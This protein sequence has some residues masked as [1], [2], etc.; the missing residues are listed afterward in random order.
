MTE[1]A[2]Q[3]KPEL[4]E[5]DQSIKEA[6]EE[7]PEESAPQTEE[8]SEPK[9]VEA[10]ADEESEG[11]D[12]K[13]VDNFQKRINKVTADKWEEKRRADALQK[14]LDDIEANKPK[15]SEVVEP[16]IEDF[17]FDD[18]KFQSALVDYR[19]DKRLQA[20]DIKLQEDSE[21][22]ASQARTATFLENAEGLAKEKPDFSEVLRNMPTLQPTVLAAVMEDSKGPELAYYLGTHLDITDKIVSMNPIAA[23]IEIGRISQRLAEPTQIKPSSAPEPIKAVSSG[24][25][26][27]SD[28]G[29]KMST[30]AWMK[31][32]NP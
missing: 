31:K 29:D 21:V 10:Q 22:R 4:T 6:L 25:V 23:A 30:E 28:I 5:L 12:N 16:K 20:N 2:E 27:S 13:P 8:I 15:S 9:E 14:K 3:V 32:Y 19:V 1:T 7:I 18:A 17:D 26:V 11:D 24:G